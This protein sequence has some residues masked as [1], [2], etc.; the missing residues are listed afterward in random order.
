MLFE[1]AGAPGSL[2]PLA[3]TEEAS[4]QRLH[5]G[6]MQP[7]ALL[8]MRCQAHLVH[9]NTKNVLSSPATRP[10]ASWTTDKM[11]ERAGEL[12]SPICVSAAASLRRA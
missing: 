10:H 5:A 4:S 7:A 6:Y 9:S 11:I 3:H 12:I 2:P 1:Q 8:A